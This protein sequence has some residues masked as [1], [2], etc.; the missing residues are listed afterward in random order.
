MLLQAAGQGSVALTGRSGDKHTKT[1]HHWDLK[2]RTQCG[3]M[4]VHTVHT[5]V[6]T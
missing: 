4:Y 6:H 3:G 2:R 1:S 5:H